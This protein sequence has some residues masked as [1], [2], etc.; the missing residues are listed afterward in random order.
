MGWYQGLGGRLVWQ[1]G[2]VRGERQ[3]APSISPDTNMVTANWHR[4]VRVRIAND[5]LPGDYLFKL[6]SSEGQAYV[7]MT[8]RDDSSDAAVLLVNAVTTWQAYTIGADTAS[9]SVRT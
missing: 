9:T 1:S 7:P 4:S 3:S 8:V 6:V 2:G 5:W